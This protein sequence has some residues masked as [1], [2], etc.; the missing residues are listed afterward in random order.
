VDVL[1]TIGCSLLLIGAV[2]ALFIRPLKRALTIYVVILIAGL[3][4]NFSFALIQILSLPTITPVFSL[5]PSISI[6]F[7]A[8]GLALFF[9]LVITV[10]AIPTVLASYSYLLSYLHKESAV[11]AFCAAFAVMFLATQLLVLSTHAIAFLVLWEMMTLTAYLGMLLDKEKEEVQHGSLIYFV[12]THVATFFLYIFFFLLH[13]HSGSWMF[14][15]FHITPESGAVFYI[16][17]L[18]GLMG[19]GIKAGFMP[20]H[21]WLPMAHPIA[22]TILSAFLSGVIL[23]TGIYGIFRIVEFCSPLSAWIG[24][25][26]IG[27]G[28]F[29]GIFGIWNALAQ[30]D[31]KRMLA[32]SSIE[33]VGIIGIGIGLGVIGVAYSVQSLVW[34]GFGGALFHT[35]NHAI[36]KSLLFLGSGVIYRNY[37]TRRIDLMGGIVH[38][39]PWFTGLF[40]IGSIAICGIPPLNGFMSEFLIYKGFLESASVLGKYFP[41]FMLLMSVG[42]AFVGGLALAAFTKVNGVM[43]LGSARTDRVTFTVSATEY[44]ALGILAFFCILFGVFPQSLLNTISSVIAFNHWGIRIQPYAMFAQWDVMSLVFLS[45]LVT[46]VILIGWK[47]LSMQ[48][49][50]ARAWGCGYEFPTSRMQYSGTSFSDEMV[51]IASTALNVEKEITL[52]IYSFPQPSTF[53]TTTRDFVLYKIISPLMTAFHWTT[54]RFTWLQAGK[55]QVYISFSIAVLL[56]YLLLS[57]FI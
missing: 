53:R 10:S 33:N 32:Y 52:P 50:I 25:G 2:G 30:T 24:L 17:C 15:S 43:F 35:F 56:F 42:L 40:L 49:R 6:F 44:I 21:F 4:L 11:R 51:T 13:E 57:I 41:L 48:Q 34:L 26:M 45:V 16:V 28:I 18:F 8:D 23:K 1:F 3:S 54:G 20:F 22:P 9:L 12:T 36:F 31:I 38:R 14:S 5:F 46:V 27:I 47:K 55:I 29:T 7:Q 37:H 39:A 19:F